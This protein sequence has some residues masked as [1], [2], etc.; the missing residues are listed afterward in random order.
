MS[1]RARSGPVTASELMAQLESDPAWVRERAA[2]QAE[3]DR[4]GRQRLRA[5]APV[6]TELRR[7][8]FDVESPW[9]LYLLAPYAGAI[10]I[11]MRH[12]KDASYDEE[13]RA[14]IARALAV[15][16]ARGTWRDLVD[17]YRETDPAQDQLKQALAAALCVIADRGAADELIRLLFDTDLGPSRILLLGAVT[18][19]RLPA[20]WDVI[21]K[22]LADDDLSKE[23]AHML[24]QRELRVRRQQGG[25]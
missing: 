2:Q 13:A 25:R 3:Q 1:K 16:E 6:T 5:L 10:P 17:L 20:A 8:G 24:H 4:L 18:R 14:A 11:L 7:A 15:P 22:A 19:L 23:A 21:A 9:Q 12:L